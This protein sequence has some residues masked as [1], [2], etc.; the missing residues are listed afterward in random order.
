MS[1]S[2]AIFYTHLVASVQTKG[3][4]PAPGG[5][6]PVLA[7]L[8]LTEN[9]QSRCLM[10]DY[11]RDSKPDA[12]DTDRAV[13]LIQEF[14][15]LG[16][17]ALRLLGG[18]PLL[19]K[20]LFEILDRTRHLPF[21]RLTLATNGLLLTRKLDDINRSEITHLTVS[22]NG[23]A[24]S[25]DKIRGVPGGFDQIV[26]GLT[27]I[28]G[29]RVK[30]V[31]L[32]TQSLA[33]SIDALL[34]LCRSRGWN[35]DLVLPSFDLP[36]AKHEGTVSALEEIWPDPEAAGSILTKV[37]ERGYITSS[38]ARAAWAYLI[39]R[40]Y[41]QRCCILGHLQM[42]VRANG[43]LLSGCYELD[44]IGNVLDTSVQGILES[45][46][47]RERLKQMF[48]MECPA[49]V[50]GWQVSYMAQKPLGM[51]AYAARR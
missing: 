44:P 8:N 38:L 1:V 4:I 35:F 2:H 15:S 3:T 20:D 40:E 31:S 10:C 23:Y 32:I 33:E 43:D 5:A 27:R 19:R 21:R 37:R 29:R 12:I 42:Q 41:P 30:V 22:L 6:R 7:T 50:C 26:D 9:C 16:V 51:L 28:R 47:Y 49:C 46:A 17:S 36:Y 39:D 48:E 25:H 11:W 13:G 24:A 14:H 34:D 18:E 45:P